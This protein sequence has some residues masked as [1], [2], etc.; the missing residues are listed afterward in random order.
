MSKKK[1][2]FSNGVYTPPR[3]SLV[4]E[5]IQTEV[6]V[7]P[8]IGY[9]PILIDRSEKSVDVIGRGLYQSDNDCELY[10]NLVE[11][12]MMFQVDSHI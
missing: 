1:K 5:D 4:G 12:E 7:T 10:I 3:I 6:T 2:E 9:V 11:S 8:E